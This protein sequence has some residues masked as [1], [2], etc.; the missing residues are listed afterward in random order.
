MK[1][2]FALLLVG[3]LFISCGDK[4]PVANVSTIDVPSGYSH[5]LF[6]TKPLDKS[7]TFKAYMVSMDGDDDG[8]LLG[9][10]EFVSYHIKK[11]PKLGKGAKRPSKWFETPE[12]NPYTPS[13]DS[14]KHSGYSRGHLCKKYIAWRLGA[15]ADRET[16]NTANACPQIQKFNAGIWLDLENKTEKWADK[17]NEVWV[18][19]GPGFDKTRKIEYIGDAGEM[20]VAIPHYFWKIIARV[21]NGNV[22]VLAF[23]YPHKAISKESDKYNHKKYAVKIDSIEALTGLDFFSKYE[24]QDE[25]ESVKNTKIWEIK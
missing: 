2:L 4:K 5:N 16:H 8:K 9:I 22:K 21:D 15:E 23:N 24:N 3:F 6:D 25:L 7:H 20:K 12:L 19:C 18:I 13:D 1:N 17:F 10:P 11:S 14:Y